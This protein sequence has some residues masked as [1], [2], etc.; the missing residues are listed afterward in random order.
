MHGDYA[1]EYQDPLSSILKSAGVPA[2]VT[3]APDY[4][5]GDMEEGIVGG[6]LGAVAGGLVGGPA[7][8]LQGA[9][10]GSSI[11]DAISPDETDETIEPTLPAMEDET[12][13]CDSPLAGQYGHSGKMKPVSKDLSFLDR[14]KELSGLKRG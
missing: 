4:M 1:E 10:L 11:G 12:D 2:E 7:G 9:S 6:A 8:A 14:L 13:E 5:T 3:P